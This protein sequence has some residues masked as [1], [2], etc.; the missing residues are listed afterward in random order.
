MRRCSGVT[1]M[2]K[3]KLD[4]PFMFVSIAEILVLFALVFYMLWVVRVIFIQVQLP[5]K[6]I[7]ENPLILEVED[8]RQYQI[9]EASGSENESYFIYV[10][11]KTGRL[12]RVI[13]AQRTIFQE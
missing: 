3:D 5:A 9:L 2:K 4:F 13:Q 1:D 6:V 7:Q 11:R 12:D 8:G 10:D